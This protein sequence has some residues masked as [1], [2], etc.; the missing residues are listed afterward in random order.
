MTRDIVFG[1][2]VFTLLSYFAFARIGVATTLLRVLFAPRQPHLAAAMPIVFRTNADGSFDMITV[3]ESGGVDSAVSLV[4]HNNNKNV[5]AGVMRGCLVVPARGC[6]VIAE[7]AP[8][9]RFP[10]PPGGL[11]ILG[12]MV[13][14]LRVPSLE[15]FWSAGRSPTLLL[16]S[17]CGGTHGLFKEKGG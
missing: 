12:V 8:P 9:P 17:H 5:L 10:K 13:Y 7:A 3:D 1:F 11:K 2:T 16:L 15:R 6:L 4:A 14:T